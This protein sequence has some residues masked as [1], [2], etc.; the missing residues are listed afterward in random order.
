MTAPGLFAA[1]LYWLLLVRVR[2]VVAVVVIGAVCLGVPAAAPAQIGVPAIIAAVSAVTSYIVNTLGAILREIQN[3]A[4]AVS[5]LISAFRSLWETIVYPRDLIAQARALAGLMITEFRGIL[6]ALLGL[7][8]N[9]ATLPNPRALEAVMRNRQMNDVAALDGAYARVFGALPPP[10]HLHAA[11]RE[12]IDVSDAAVKAVLKT[13]KA[14]ERAIDFAAGASQ[15]IEDDATFQAPGSAAYLAGGGLVAAVRSQA[16]MMRMLAAE[17]RL[18]AA[19]LAHEN[20]RRKRG[21]AFAEELRR[22]SADA[23][24]RRP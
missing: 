6:N 14:S 4:R 2:R 8:L 17:M 18:E 9:S 10:A 22:T 23:L 13:A 12:L 5:G 21:A 7:N 1:L 15:S 11:D 20:M 16:V 24:R 19:S 3:A